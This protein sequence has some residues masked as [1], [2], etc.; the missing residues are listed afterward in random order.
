MLFRSRQRPMVE[1]C[2]VRPR[3]HRFPGAGLSLGAVTQ[4]PEPVIDCPQHFPTH[5][6]SMCWCT[7]AWVG[8]NRGMDAKKAHKCGTRRRAI[9]PVALAA[10]GTALVM[11]LVAWASPVQAQSRWTWPMTDHVL[12]SRFDK[13]AKN[14]LPGHRGVDIAEI[15]RAHV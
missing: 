1:R 4:C 10:A 8:Q 13:P 6:E 7:S 15:G 14:W 2:V 11:Y 5:N 12:L 3:S 9:A